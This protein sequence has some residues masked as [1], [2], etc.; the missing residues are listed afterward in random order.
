MWWLTCLPS[1]DSMLRFIAW[2]SVQTIA[3]ISCLHYHPEIKEPHTKAM[4]HV[5]S[6]WCITE[7]KHNPTVYKYVGARG[8]NGMILLNHMMPW[9]QPRDDLPS[10]VF[11]LVNAVISVFI[12]SFIYFPAQEAFMLCQCAA[13]EITVLSSTAF[14]RIKK[15]TFPIMI[16]FSIRLC[17]VPA[18]RTLPANCLS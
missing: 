11:W 6:N 16:G 12:Y 18:F 7:N 14:Y 9:D 13:D 10:C 5:W 3:G 1:L 17:N 2:A 15:R 8:R 4:S